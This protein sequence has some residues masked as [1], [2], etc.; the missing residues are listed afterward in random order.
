MLTLP[1]HNRYD[2]SVIGER[3][4]YS[5]P[6]GKRLAFCTTTNI[7]VYAYRK[8][9]G[10]DPAK[11]GEPQQQRN[12]SWRDYGNRVGIWRLFDLFEQFKLPAAHNINSMLY[13]YHPQIT[14][15]IRARGDEVVGHGRTNAE[16]QGDLWELDEKRLIDDVTRGDLRSARASRRRAGWARPR[17]RATSRS[18]C[19]K[20]AG[21]KYVMDWPAD[22]QPFW[23]KTRSGPILS[24]PYPAELNDSASI[25]HRENTPQQFADMIVDQFDE[26]VEQCVANPLVMTLVA[27]SVRG[28]PAVPA[29]VAAQGAQALRRASQA[30]PGVVDHAGAGRGLLLRAAAGDHSGR[31]AEIARE[32]CLRPA[33]RRSIVRPNSQSKEDHMAQSLPQRA[34]G[35]SGINVSAIGLGCMSFSGVYGPS[36][37]AAAIALIHEALDAGITMLDSSDAYG[38]GQNETLVGNAIK[39]R[40]AGVVLATKFGNLGGAGGKYADGRP[41]FVVSSCEASLKRLGVDVIDLYY[42]H[43]ID[44][45]VPIEDTVGAMA[46]LVQQGKVRALGLS[47]AAPKT[48]ARAHKVHPIAAVQNEFSLLYREQADDTR[49]TT[50]DLGISFVAYAPLGRGLLTSDIADP[51]T[52]ARATPA[53]ASRATPATTSRTTARWRRRS[54]RSPSARAA[55]RRSSRSPGCWRRARTS[56][57]F[58]GTKQK[59]RVL[60]N[61]GAL[62]VKLSDAELA[63]IASAVPAGAVKGTRYPEAQMASLYI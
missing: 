53:S 47:E 3:K 13:E 34:L 16:R 2:Y 4:D 18:I 63:E 12:Y 33:P 35:K 5:W 22:D 25:I 41:E 26:M 37:D 43:R 28:R 21:Y 7:E 56:S 58:P 61:I 45:T 31:G 29:A 44:P 23:L 27:A 17:P 32:S 38:K 46:K 9:T 62:N 51:A 11:K 6:G 10:W 24:V 54:R 48:I 55:R 14:D 1:K 52:L 19:L 60:E 49:K 15:K 30:R 8:G 59:K 36:E 40:R 42:A 57:R 50:R 20:E 39:G